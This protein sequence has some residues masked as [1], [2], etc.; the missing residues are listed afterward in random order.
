MLIRPPPPPINSPANNGAARNS[1]NL[2]SPSMLKDTP[3]GVMATLQRSPANNM[4]PRGPPP[5]SSI[6]HNSMPSGL[7]A[8]P[9]PPIVMPPQS[10]PPTP[11]VANSPFAQR[12]PIQQQP[13]SAP[14]SPGMNKSNVPQGAATPKKL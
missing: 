12:P 1:V 6:S 13:P 4:P 9:K 14:L 3:P 8:L 2:P 5:P 11:P 7:A 10:K